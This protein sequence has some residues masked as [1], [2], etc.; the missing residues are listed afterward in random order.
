M[1][2]TLNKYYLKEMIVYKFLSFKLNFLFTE[3]ESFKDISQ[4]N[5]ILQ[6]TGHPTEQLMKQI[7]QDAR[8]YLENK[9][10]KTQRVN[11]ISRFSMRLCNFIT[12]SV[13]FT[14]NS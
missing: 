10:I 9:P 4:L 2:C 14:P 6:V 11:L 12:N 13:D 3:T 8:T 5:L 1:K 7:N